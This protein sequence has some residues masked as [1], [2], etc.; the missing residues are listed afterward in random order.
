MFCISNGEMH[1]PEQYVAWTK[2]DVLMIVANWRVQNNI[3]DPTPVAYLL[4]LANLLLFN[5]TTS[6]T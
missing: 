2:R 1:V 3:T 5:F 4:D 6:S